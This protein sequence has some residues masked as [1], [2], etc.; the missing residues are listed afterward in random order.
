M[1][2]T[3]TGKEEVGM[4]AR[5]TATCQVVRMGLYLSMLLSHVS[6]T[7]SSSESCCR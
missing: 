4:S 3:V 2:I 1:T 6:P 7:R 5:G